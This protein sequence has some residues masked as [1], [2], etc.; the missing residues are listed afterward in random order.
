MA[1]QW[2]SEKSFLK[3]EDTQQSAAKR[4]RCQARDFPW[5]AAEED[6]FM[7]EVWLFQLTD[8]M[9]K[10]KLDA[11][12]QLISLTKRHPMNEKRMNYQSTSEE[13]IL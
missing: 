11:K 6:E 5:L 1:K 2:T 7:L 12:G 10:P 9:Q 3:A 8:D 4:S 13:A